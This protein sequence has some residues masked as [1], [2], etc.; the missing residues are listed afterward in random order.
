M[1]RDK[2]KNILRKI[3]F[4]GCRFFLCKVALMFGGRPDT[5]RIFKIKVCIII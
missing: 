5:S 3:F 1:S 4:S 2:T